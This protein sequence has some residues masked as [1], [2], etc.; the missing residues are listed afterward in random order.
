MMANCRDCRVPSINTV[1]VPNITYITRLKTFHC[2]SVLN[3][4]KFAQLDFFFCFSSFRASSAFISHIIIHF[5]FVS[6]FLLP[7]HLAIG[8]DSSKRASP[9]P[10]TLLTNHP[11]VLVFSSGVN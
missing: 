11:S 7:S 4:L 2:A 10:A 8:G 6:Q 1:F 3:P 5:S 9:G